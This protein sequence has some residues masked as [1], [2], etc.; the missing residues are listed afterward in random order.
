[1]KPLTNLEI[2]KIM[3]KYDNYRGTF[4]KD[5]LPKTMKKNE[6]TVVNLQGYFAGDGTHWVCIYNDEKSDKVKYFDSFGLVPPNEVIK[7]MKTTNKNIIYNDSQ[8]QNMD[9]ILCGYY[10]IY[11]IEQRNEGRTADEVLLDFHDNPTE[12]NKKFMKFYLDIL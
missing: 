4:S 12:F 10:C 11:Y 8:I 7:Y 5:M 3:T 6:A 1:M 9:S 2:D